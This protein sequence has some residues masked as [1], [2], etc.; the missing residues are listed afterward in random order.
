MKIN[1]SLSKIQKKNNE[2]EK[3]QKIETHNLIKHNIPHNT[4]LEIKKKK[5]TRSP[6]TAREKTRFRRFLTFKNLVREH[7]VAIS[8]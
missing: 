5:F 1:M 4:A 7:G 8:I 6:G 2:N 3:F